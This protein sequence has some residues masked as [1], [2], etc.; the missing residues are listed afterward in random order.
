M[1][2]AR[3]QRQ[4]LAE[5]LER[6]VDREAG[7]DRGDLEENAARLPE[8]DRAEVEAVDHRRRVRTGSGDAP[9][10][11]VVLV[12]RRRPRDVVDGARAGDAGFLRRL[13]VRVVRAA[14]GAAHLPFRVVLR[15]ERQGLFEEA[16]A[17][18]G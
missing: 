14:L 15:L 3:R 12:L 2:V 13:V 1:L 4:P 8:V 10:P 18:A 17:R 7:A 9:L 5:R 6:L 16:L 11:V